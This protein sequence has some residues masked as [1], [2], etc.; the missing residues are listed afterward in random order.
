MGTTEG[1][2]QDTQGLT[3]FGEG[4]RPGCS[5]GNRAEGGGLTSR[6]GA[7][8]S[9][10]GPIP[11]HPHGPSLPGHLG[12]C[13]RASWLLLPHLKFQLSAQERDCH[14]LPH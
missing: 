2:P 9:A 8:P 12:R 11:S 1:L 14:S 3:F 10:S 7:A 13:Q 4:V 5:L 6:S